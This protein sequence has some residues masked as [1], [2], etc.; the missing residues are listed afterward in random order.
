MIYSFI[1]YLNLILSVLFCGTLL[2]IITFFTKDSIYISG[3]IRFWAKWN[4]FFANIRFDVSG[5]ENIKKD[6]SYIF[7]SNHESL[8]DIPIVLATLPH[9][10]LFLAKKELFNI[11]VFGRAINNVGMIPIDRK[12]TDKAKSSINKAAKDIVNKDASILVYPE[13]TRSLDGM[14]KKFKSGGFILAI[15]SRLPIVP[16]TMV[17]SIDVHRK[18]SFYI[19]NKVKVKIH[20][21]SPIRTSN[22]NI[23]NKDLLIKK[24]FQIIQKIKYENS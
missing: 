24:T 12:N 7:I 8:S 1:I 18:G 5:L 10:I 9:K 22:Y 16:I 15:K 6:D 11:P 23:E 3:I 21:D 19:N 14:L 20:I 17:K 4:L 2:I 13:G